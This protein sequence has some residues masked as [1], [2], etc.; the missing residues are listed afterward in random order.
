MGK[1]RDIANK[2]IEQLIDELVA[3]EKSYVGRSNCPY[4]FTLF[5]AE[6]IEKPKSC[7]DCETCK[8]DFYLQVNNNLRKLFIVE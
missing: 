6:E 8:E 3:Y 2:H 1:K 4:I 5:G 7:D